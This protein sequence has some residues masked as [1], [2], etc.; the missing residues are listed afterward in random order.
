MDDA[1]T[2]SRIRRAGK[3]IDGACETRAAGH[4]EDAQTGLKTAQQRLEELDPRLPALGAIETRMEALVEPGLLQTSNLGRVRTILDH[5]REKWEQAEV[6]RKSGSPPHLVQAVAAYDEAI[7]LRR[8]L[9]L[10]NPEYRNDLAGALMNKGVALETLGSPSHL[11]QAVAANDEA[12]ALFREL[13][14]GNPE[15]RNDLASALMNK[16]YVLK[17]LGSPS[18]LAQ[19]VATYD[20]AIALRR[21]LPQDNP[22]YRNGLAGALMNKGNVLATLGSPT[23]LAQAVAAHDEAIALRRTLPQDNTE[24]RADLATALMNKGNSLQAL[25]SPPHLAQAVVSYD[26]AIAL[27]RKLPQDNPEYRNDL[28]TALMNKGVTLKTLGSPQHLAQAVAAYDE[29]LVLCPAEQGLA[30]LPMADTHG[31]TRWN[32]AAACYHLRRFAEAQEE[33]DAGLAFLRDLE[34]HGIFHLRP[35]REQLFGLALGFTLAAKQH[36]VL[37]EIILEHLDPANP[38][39][40]PA[41][42]AMH[43]RALEHLR[44]GLAELLRTPGAQAHVRGYLDAL[45]RLAEIAILYFAGTAAAAELRALDGEHRGDPAAARAEL[46]A[47]SRERPDDPEGWRVLGDFLTRRAEHEAAEQAYLTLARCLVFAA[48]ASADL[49]DHARRIAQVGGAILGYK[50]TALP[51][52]S[53]ERILRESDVLLLWLRLGFRDAV[54]RPAPDA[55]LDAARF[56]AWQAALDQALAKTQQAIVGQRDKLLAVETRQQREDAARAT[57]EFS[58]QLL[59]Q[60]TQGLA[61]PWQAFVDHILLAWK[62]ISQRHVPAW[63]AATAASEHARILAEAAEALTHAVRQATLDLHPGELAEADAALAAVL[64]EAVWHGIL[65]DSE[66]R[67]LAAGQR[68]LEVQGFARYAGME[69]GLA[70]ETALRERLFAPLRDWVREQHTDLQMLDRPLLEFMS[71][72]RDGLTFGPMVEFFGALLQHWRKPPAPL[73]D[74]ARVMLQAALE[75]RTEVLI[76]DPGQRAGRIEALKDANRLRNRCAHMEEA[77]SQEEVAR[78]WQALVVGREQGF[79]HHL[80]AAAWVIPDRRQLGEV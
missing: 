36:P 74:A 56:T 53:Q 50:L 38:G 15:Y 34:L 77:P 2:A 29:A 59:Q 28:A 79:F 60:A 71:G 73:H 72:Q 25:G 32:K 45:G 18:H 9:P 37:P 39:A 14:R 11:A 1:I 3:D 24:Y 23:H 57:L 61:T 67:F 44:R 51:P 10:D 76:G 26:E 13:P 21:E 42:R 41:S 6:L 80:G 17:A 22:E 19:A 65:N 58:S 66:R 8:E 4:E 5:A 68:C 52:G 64:G 47:Y 20:E 40:A 78:R 46:E 75:D 33:A 31:K 43:G 70:L 48:P 55:R 63:L 62:D 54:L 35:M 27:R 30:Y 49:A 12:I 16:G 7:A 69:L